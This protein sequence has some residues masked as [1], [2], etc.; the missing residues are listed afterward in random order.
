MERQLCNESV[1]KE[2][3]K[4]LGLTIK[5]VRELVSTQSEYVKYVMESGTFDSIRLPYLGIFKSKP[6]EVQML[7]HLKGMTKE[8]QDDFKRLVR[9]GKIRLNTWETKKKKDE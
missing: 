6:K 5:E 7:E 2:V 3:A 9:T 4:E 1:V 8:Q